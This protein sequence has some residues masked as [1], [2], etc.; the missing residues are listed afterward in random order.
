MS[1]YT[2]EVRGMNSW[3]TFPVDGPSVSVEAGRI[4]TAMNAARHSSAIAFFLVIL[5]SATLG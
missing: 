2:D 3:E 5:V 4:A 1:L